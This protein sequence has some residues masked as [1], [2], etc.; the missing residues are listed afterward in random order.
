MQLSCA[1]CWQQLQLR[2]SRP[3]ADCGRLSVCHTVIAAVVLVGL[4]VAA[5]HVWSC[6]QRLL[7]YRLLTDQRSELEFYFKFYFTSN[8]TNIE[9]KWIFPM[10]LCYLW[11]NYYVTTLRCMTPRKSL[12]YS[13]LS[14]QSMI[15]VHVRQM[16]TMHA[17]CTSTQCTQCMPSA[18]PP[19]V[20]N[21]P[22][23]LPPNVRNACQVHVYPM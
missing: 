8:I 11:V 23:A 6:N 5:S 12:R 18:L 13:E 3:L 16:H 2:R 19:N 10:Y 9:L 14:F 15:F 7:I 4:S 22:S 1:D 20:R 17:K 21:M